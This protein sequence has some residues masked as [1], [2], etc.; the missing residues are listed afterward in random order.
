MLSCVGRFRWRRE[1]P[2][3]PEGMFGTVEC[4]ELR[5]MDVLRVVS[6][7]RVTDVKESKQSLVDLCDAKS[8]ADR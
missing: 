7:S 1:A 6:D 3:C 2:A 5:A 8:R 4:C